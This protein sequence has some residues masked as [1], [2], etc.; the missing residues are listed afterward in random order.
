MDFDL[1][2]RRNY[3]WGK[4]LE[5]ESVQIFLDKICEV[6]INYCVKNGITPEKLDVID[7]KITRDGLIVAN[8]TQKG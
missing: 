5:N 3:L 1:G 2:E 6:G 7:G 4:L 8:F